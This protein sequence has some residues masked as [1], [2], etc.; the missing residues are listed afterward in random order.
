MVINMMWISG[1]LLAGYCLRI[2][3]EDI[4][5]EISK[6][7]QRKRQYQ[8]DTEVLRIVSGFEGWPEVEVD[9]EQIT[10]NWR[11]RVM[12]WWAN[13]WIDSQPRSPLALSG[14]ASLT[15]RAVRP[16]QDRSARYAGR[17]RKPEVLNKG[18]EDGLPVQK[19]KVSG[20]DSSQA[21]PG[22]SSTDGGLVQQG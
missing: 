15:T 7:R 22:E 19:E 11:E 21:G 5:A 16:T 6:S 2:L 10:P 4:S 18:G 12:D 8:E 13:V 20:R 17:H 9:S 3:V 1:L 14:F